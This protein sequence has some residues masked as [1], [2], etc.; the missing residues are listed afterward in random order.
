M[1]G[2]SGRRIT[3]E[4][5]SNSREILISRIAD[6]LGKHPRVSFAYLFGSAN[7]GR[8]LP[9]S[10][11][12]IAVHITDFDQDDKRDLEY[13]IS[14]KLALEDAVRRDVDLVVLNE[15]PPLLKKEVLIGGTKIWDRG[16]GYSRAFRL[17]TVW[18]Y[19]DIKPYLDYQFRQALRYFE[20]KDR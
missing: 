12:D 1:V 9:F 2:Q 11:I 18:E 8:L 16:D 7:K 20:K 10:D 6:I 17:R 3:V 19:D 5:S 14:I 15:A 13:Y 4:S